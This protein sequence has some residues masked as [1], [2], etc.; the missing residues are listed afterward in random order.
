MRIAYYA[1]LNPPLDGIPSGDRRVAQLYL[2]ALRHSDHLV[3]LA[4]TFR[5]FDGVGNPELQETLCRE[6]RALAAGLL[7]RWQSMA[8]ALRPDV[9][10]TYHLYYKAPD[11]LGPQITR[12]LGIPYVVAEPSHAPKRVR[13]AWALGH[14]ACEQALRHARLLLCPSRDDIAALSDL[15]Q[16]SQ[17]IVH[18][19]PFLD[20]RQFACDNGGRM[21]ARQRRAREIGVDP[22]WPWLL[23]VAMMRPGDKLASYR[24]LASTLSRLL[25]LPWRLIVAGDGP[26][27]D[28]VEAALNAAIPG[29]VCF[30]G[31]LAATALAETYAA[32]DLLVWPAVNEAYGMALLEAQAAGLPVV[33]SNLRGVPDVVID[34]KSGLL[35]PPGDTQALAALV[36]ELLESP[37]R[38]RQMGDFAAT[39][40]ARERDVGVAAARLTSLLEALTLESS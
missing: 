27:R 1:P 13:G 28:Q 4:S 16:G 19:P 12:A 39:R 29:R 26:A 10:L 21:R 20:V 18:M 3:E 40:V 8:L 33:A 36:R 14:R 22:Q 24:A 7:Q 17:R 9:W 5:S 32:C 35:A 30:L 38:R 37:A 2:Q 11:W 15:L 25:D 34:G 31:E 23:A 6:G